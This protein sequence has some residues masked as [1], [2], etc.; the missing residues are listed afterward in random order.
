MCVY[1]FSL[2]IAFVHLDE[3]AGTF[4]LFPCLEAP[5]IA[6]QPHFYGADETLLDNFESGINPVKEDHAIYMHF[7][8]VRS[9]F[10]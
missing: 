3:F 6:S 8:L 1:S 4:D 9:G 7:E 10:R 2:L 5:L